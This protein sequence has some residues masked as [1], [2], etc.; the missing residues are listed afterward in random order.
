MIIERLFIL[1]AGLMGA[2][3]VALAA[4][5]A[6]QSSDNLE[7]AARFLLLHAPALLAIGLFGRGLMLR[8]G[9]SVLLAGVLLFSGD[10]AMR[11]LCRRAAVSFRGAYRR[12]ADDRRLDSGRPFGAGPA[13]PQAGFRTTVASGLGGAATK[14]PHLLHTTLHWPGTAETSRP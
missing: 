2:A 13:S 10:L 5:A 7:T 9:G 4:A 14:P 12:N 1:A 11:H 8:T 6:H 3:G